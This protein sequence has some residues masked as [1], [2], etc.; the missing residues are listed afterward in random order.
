VPVFAH[1]V[2]IL[3]VGLVR[4]RHRARLPCPESVAVTVRGLPG[5]H[6]STHVISTESASGDIP[7]SKRGALLTP[8]NRAA[9]AVAVAVAVADPD[10]AAVAGTRFSG[11]PACRNV[12][13]SSRL[14]SGSPP[15]GGVWRSWSSV[16]LGHRRSSRR[17]SWWLWR[18]SP[19]RHS[20]GSPT[21]CCAHRNSDAGGT[22][23]CTA[24]PPLRELSC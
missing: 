20:R 13:R 2:A 3:S 17:P 18:M 15:C 7:H 21:R 6:N 11:S 16:V 23:P 19:G 24:R 4:G 5:D 12:R 1:R 14:R 8:C 22:I 10:A 9:A